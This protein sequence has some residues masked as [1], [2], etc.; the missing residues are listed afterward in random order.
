MFKFCFLKSLFFRRTSLLS[1]LLIFTFVLLNTAVATPFEARVTSLKDSSG[2]GFNTQQPKIRFSAW[3]PGTGR[4][5]FTL[6]RY[7]PVEQQA[8]FSSNNSQEIII[9]QT[10]IKLFRG[11]VRMKNKTGKI[12]A[13]VIKH[14]YN[15]YLSI[16]FVD[17]NPRRGN[18]ILNRLVFNLD[19][20]DGKARLR[21]LKK[22]PAGLHH[23]DFITDKLHLAEANHSNQQT[24]T[25]SQPSIAAA[26]GTFKVLKLNIDADQYWYN[27]Y[28]NSSNAVITSMLNDAETIYE[29]D[30][31]ITFEVVRQNV[32]TDQT[33]GTNDVYDKLCNYQNFISGDSYLKDDPECTLTSTPGPQSYYGQADAYHLFTG[34]N[35]AGSTIGLAFLGAI[36]RTPHSTMAV[37]Q[38]TTSALTPVTFA[39]ENAHLLSAIHDGESGWNGV[40]NASCQETS[41]FIMSSII[42]NNP[43]ESFSNCSQTL[44][45]EYIAEYA[46]CLDETTLEITEPDDVSLTIKAKVNKRGRFRAKL[47]ISGDM[48]LAEAS[49]CQ[50][51]LNFGPNNKILNS[52]NIQKTYSIDALENTYRKKLAYAIKANKKGIKKNGLVNAQ[53][54]CN[55]TVVATSA[56]ATL[57]TSNIEQSAEVKVKRWLK[58][59]VAKL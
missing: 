43:P 2:L 30:L 58:K 21:R 38:L 32:F 52:G 25:S 23:N 8:I 39:H 34:Q 17:I 1:F 6:N 42:Y 53:L 11:T 44:I 19:H 40:K 26:T 4:M 59:L 31:S 56:T 54:V 46:S 27:V 51:Q 16:S 35:L 12:A 22:L 24:Q 14:D 28:G 47:T 48:S 18:K 9:D 10:P 15:R 29:N 13:S 33:F 7:L 37:T 36:C 20:L 5:T 50:L 41:S 45:N 55:G 3:L 57:N 49:S